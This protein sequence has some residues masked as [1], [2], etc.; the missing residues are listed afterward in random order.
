MRVAVL[1]ATA[2]TVAGCASATGQSTA[3]AAGR[4]AQWTAAS[5][6]SRVLDL[7]GP[8]RDGSLIVASAG[9]LSLLQPTGVLRSFARGA[10]GY[11]SPGGEEP[12]IAVSAGGAGCTFGRGTTYAL[13]LRHGSGVTAID[14]AGRARRFT[15]LPAVT[16]ENGI[17]LDHTGRFGHR[18]LVTA[19]ARSTTTVYAINCRGKVTTVTTSAP[20]VEGGIAVAPATFGR[21]A[22]DLIA[23]DEISGRIF[24]IAAD[25]SSR[26]VGDSG[27]PHGQDI[28]VES[29]GFVPARFGAG[30]SALVADRLTPHSRHPG[31]GVILRIAAAS[32]L[33]AGVRPG[34]LLGT[35]EGGAA[36]DAV[37]C[38]ATCQVRHIAN[39]P[40]A[41][42]IE[43]HIVFGARL[44]G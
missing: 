24:A 20:K 14:P 35:S 43:G 13:R 38:G 23:P 22:G 34:D 40:P 27:L 42:H 5:R 8:R 41:A 44:A 7:G 9:R 36:T 10:V 28:G 21:F 6:V 32:L 30:W 37:T 39:G 1:A 25:G 26:I 3:P 2:L 4:P 33:R 12:Y 31:D 19:T 11:V 29:A 16:R 15:A 18:L 17:A